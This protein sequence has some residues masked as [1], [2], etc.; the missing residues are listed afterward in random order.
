MRDQPYDDKSDS[1]ITEQAGDSTSVATNSDSPDAGRTTESVA[2]LQVR[3]EM[4]DDVSLD[5]GITIMVP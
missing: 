2:V 4:A 5:D 3:L 1:E